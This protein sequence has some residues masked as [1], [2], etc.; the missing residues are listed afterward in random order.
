MNTELWTGQSVVDT[1]N[2]FR[3]NIGSYDGV[4]ALG[5]NGSFSR[6]DYGCSCG[7]SRGW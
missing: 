5:D 2:N 6:G 7:A 4:A 1:I 3:F